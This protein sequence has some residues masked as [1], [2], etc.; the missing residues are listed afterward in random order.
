MKR[1]KTGAC[2]LWENN[3]RSEQSEPGKDAVEGTVIGSFKVLELH[4]KALDFT[5]SE[6]ESHHKGLTREVH[7]H[8]ILESPFRDLGE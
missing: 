3:D 5:V 6:L 7:S 2:L 8:R 4:V 1:P